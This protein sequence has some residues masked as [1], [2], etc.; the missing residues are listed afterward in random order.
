MYRLRNATTNR[1]TCSKMGAFGA[2]R[3]LATITYSKIL[4]DP[5]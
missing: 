3:C 1:L 4:L 2:L 5:V